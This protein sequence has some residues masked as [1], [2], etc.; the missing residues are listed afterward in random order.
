MENVSE[1]E[2]LELVARLIDRVGVRSSFTVFST[3]RVEG[4]ARVFGVRRIVLI[5]SQELLSPARR[6]V[7]EAVIMHE[8]I[9]VR[10]MDTLSHLLAVTAY[11]SMFICGVISL[12]LFALFPEPREEMVFVAWS[13]LLVLNPLILYATEK[14]C[15]RLREVHA[16]LKVQDA[17]IDISGLLSLVSIPRRRKSK[18]LFDV[19]ST[20]RVKFLKEP[21][22]AFVPSYPEGFSLSVILPHSI[23]SAVIYVKYLSHL[24][25]FLFPRVSL[26]ISGNMVFAVLILMILQLRNLDEFGLKFRL[27]NVFTPQAIAGFL[28][29]F[30]IFL[31]IGTLPDILSFLLKG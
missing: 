9:H 4:F 30:F 1:K 8:L 22:R 25:P 24:S 16:D 7:A 15:H 27:G 17:G 13:Q 21:Y 29:G 6:K 3:K 23:I 20:S 11:R 31:I 12:I 19:S 2:F 14:W 10:N 18:F 28:A 26:L 5:V